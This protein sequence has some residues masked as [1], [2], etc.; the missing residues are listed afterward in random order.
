LGTAKLSL[1]PLHVVLPIQATN[2]T[3][4]M[5]EGGEV[6]F[7]WRALDNL[8]V[9]LTYSRLNINLRGPPPA[10]AIDSEAAEGQS[11]R[12]QSSLALQWNATDRLAID[13]TVH[14]VDQLPRYQIKSHVRGDVRLGYRLTN[15]LQLEV[16][17]QDLLR[18]SHREFGS[19]T[20]ANAA[21]IGRSIFGRLTWRQ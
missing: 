20:D 5:T 3:T 9:S 14:Y 17:G 4:A 11:P 2:S 21:T 8:N 7:K 15:S 13:T 12:N 16:I 1:S 6:V 19:A 18:N 10:S